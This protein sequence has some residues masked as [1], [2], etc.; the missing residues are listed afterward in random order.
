MEGIAKHNGPVAQPVHETLRD[1]CKIHDLELHSYASLEAQVAAVSDDIAYNNHDL[2]DGL[3]A[4][5]FDDTDAAA[6]P[7]VGAAYAQVEAQYPKLS[8][9]RRRHEALRRVF[10]VMVED[11]IAT[12]RANLA[13]ANPE[14]VDAVRHLK[15]AMVRF[16][17]ALW[18]QLKQIRQFLFAH[19]YRAPHVVAQREHAAKVVGDLFQYYLERPGEMPGDWGEIAQ[20]DGKVRQVSDYIAGMTDR[21]ALETHAQLFEG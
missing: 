11:V 3:R 16:S 13:A 5:L 17:P 14:N 21:Y 19:M 20:A 15:S 1:Y 8:P 12:S 7:I 10:G 6:L 2:M 4:G 18:A 9:T